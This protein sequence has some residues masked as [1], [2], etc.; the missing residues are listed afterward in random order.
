MTL[1]ALDASMP[2]S[3]VQRYSASGTLTPCAPFDF[4]KSLAFMGMFTPTSGEQRLSGDSGLTKA[5][6]LDGHAVVFSVRSEG[7]VEQPQLSYTL[8]S[9]QPLTPANETALRDRIA[10]FLSLDDDMQLFYARAQLDPQFTQVIERLYGLHQVKFLTPFENACWAVLTQRVPMRMA[11]QIKD[12]L[13]M[14]FGPSLT[15]PEGVSRAFPEPATLA[16]ADPAELASIVRNER[17][18]AYLQAVTE[19]FATH[20]EGWLRSA[21]V[22]EVAAALRGVR[23]IGAWSASFILVRGL[24]RMDSALAIGEELERAAA[25]VYNDGRPLATAEMRRLLE[26]YDAVRGYWV[27]YCRNAFGVGG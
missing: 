18:V 9:A 19:F 25:Q 14:R 1:L 13:V 7:T 22:D 8:T 15:L 23:G 24:G 16:A 10:F 11:R 17:K 5:V 21:P 12:R 6:A 3:D 2:T 4:A 27:F 20:D 26:R